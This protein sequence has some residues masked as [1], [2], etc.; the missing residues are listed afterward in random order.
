MC[1]HRAARLVVETSGHTRR[2]TCPYHG[3]SYNLRGELRAVPDE[4][5]F[6]EIDKPSCGLTPV[7]CETWNGFIFVKLSCDGQSL[8]TFLNGID[9]KIE[10]HRIQ[11]WNS[12]YKFQMDIPANW[13]YVIDNFQETYHLNFVHDGSLH[14]RANGPENPMSHPLDYGFFGPHRSMSI[15]GNLAGKCQQ[16]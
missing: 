14:D 8:A 11:D 7:A 3:R 9:E 16:N 5:S 1:A 2:F 10:T 6:Y 13:K 12:S 4:A 15:W